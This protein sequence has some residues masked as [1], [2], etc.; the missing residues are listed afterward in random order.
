MPHNTLFHILLRYM[1][2]H[3]I[4]KTVS[5]YSWWNHGSCVIFIPQ[6]DT[7]IA[8]KSPTTN[9]IKR[10]PKLA[11]GTTFYRFFNQRI[12]LQHYVTVKKLLFQTL[13]LRSILLIII[14]KLFLSSLRST[15]SPADPFAPS[16]VSGHPS[17]RGSS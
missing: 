2:S 13:T 7:F 12:I 16:P 3:G 17:P 14:G 11:V 5:L 8:S 15:L 4:L 6:K 9:I 1:H 10:I